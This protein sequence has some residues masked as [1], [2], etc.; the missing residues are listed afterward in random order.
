MEVLLLN[1]I[2][3]E[4]R[5]SVPPKVTFIYG[6]THKPFEKDLNF[7]GYAEWVDVYNSG[8]WVVDT[9][10][11]QPLH[12]GA[13]IFIDENLD[14]ASI[15][16]YN[17]T[18]KLDDYKVWVSEAAHPGDV[19][20]PLFSRLHPLVDPLKAPWNDFSVTVARAVS[21]REQ[22]LRARINKAAY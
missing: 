11:P 2:K 7:N 8:G 5:G 13:V 21:V 20:G 19:P 14:A 18:D 22:D 4:R 10:D 1:Q 3:N 15:R 17:E 12:G 6:H 16:M 9:V